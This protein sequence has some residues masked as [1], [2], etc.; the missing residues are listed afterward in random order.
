MKLFV[1]VNGVLSNP[2]SF[3]WTD[4][5][6]V[7]IHEHG[8]GEAD[9]YE[10][11]AMVLTRRLGRSRRVRELAELVNAY[12]KQHEIALIGHSNGCDLIVRA[13]P[14]ITQKVRHVHLFS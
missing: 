13:L 12:T 14:E 2:S 9:K 11:K 5:A 8:F 1:F 7:W 6:V 10:Y 4:R 3:E